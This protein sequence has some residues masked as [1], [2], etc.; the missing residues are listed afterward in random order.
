NAASCVVYGMPQAAAKLHAVT[1]EVPLSNIA[2][3]ILQHFE[4]KISGGRHDS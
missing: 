4:N 3:T 2:K 1:L